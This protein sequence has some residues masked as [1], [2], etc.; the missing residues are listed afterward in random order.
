MEDDFLK[1]IEKMDEEPSNE[2][3]EIDENIEASNSL[4]DKEEKVI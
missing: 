1:E 2:I 3:V 4:Y